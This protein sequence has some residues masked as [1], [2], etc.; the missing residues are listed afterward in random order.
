[1]PTSAS[2]FL[3]SMITFVGST[4]GMRVTVG[5]PYPFNGI[6]GGMYKHLVM[7]ANLAIDVIP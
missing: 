1:M 5:Y 3:G 6:G 7:G 4:E 2:Q